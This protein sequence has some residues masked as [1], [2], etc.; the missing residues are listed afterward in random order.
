MS[1]NWLEGGLGNL[2]LIFWSTVIYFC[3]LLKVQPT[4]FRSLACV[5]ECPQY[6]GRKALFFQ[7][8]PPPLWSKRWLARCKWWDGVKSLQ[9]SPDPERWHSTGSTATL[10]DMLRLSYFSLPR[11]WPLSPSLWNGYR[12]CIHTFGSEKVLH[13]H[14]SYHFLWTDSYLSCKHLNMM[15]SIFRP[16]VH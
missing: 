13:Y 9:Q 4:N 15:E 7:P 11:P 10:T 16:L 1:S 8:A 5:S 14:P 2:S 3:V 6:V 12:L